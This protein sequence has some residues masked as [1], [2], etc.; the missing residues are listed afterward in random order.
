MAEKSFKPAKDII[1]TV[2]SSSLTR[3]EE[4]EQD[5]KRLPSWKVQQLALRKKFKGEK[6]NPS[7]KLSREQM[8]GLRLL[9]SQFPHLTASDLGEQFKISP[10]VVRR[11]LKA[12]WQPNEKEMARIQERWQRR[13]E[14]V[15]QLYDNNQKDSTI[16]PQRE[17]LDIPKQ[18][19]IDSSRGAPKFVIRR[20]KPFQRQKSG[21]N[22][23]YLLQQ[24][25]E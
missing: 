18:I 25:N 8:E 12:K 11:I 10:E 1:K 23:L 16:T 13:G 4:E 22:K 21:R 3:K 5:I 9:K 2:N 6:W 14:R 15:Q 17:F 24:G 7:K 20:R 19:S